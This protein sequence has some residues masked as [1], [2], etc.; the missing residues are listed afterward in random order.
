[1][2]SL[3]LVERA[4][5]LCNRLVLIAL[6]KC[7]ASVCVEIFQLFEQY[8][9]TI[10]L[11]LDI[12]RRL[13][14]FFA[15]LASKFSNFMPILMQAIQLA[16]HYK[17]YP[18]QTSFSSKV[19]GTIFVWHC[20]TPLEMFLIIYLHLRS[21]VDFITKK[22]SSPNVKIQFCKLPQWPMPTNVY[23]KLPTEIMGRNRLVSILKM[24]FSKPL[25]WSE[26]SGTFSLW[27][28]PLKNCVE[29]IGLNIKNMTELVP[30]YLFDETPRQFEI[31]GPLLLDSLKST[32]GS[33]IGS[34]N[35][36]LPDDLRV[37]P[38]DIDNRV[39]ESLF[40][41]PDESLLPTCKGNKQHPILLLKHKDQDN[42]LIGKKLQL[43]SQNQN[44][45]DLKRKV[46]KDA[47][48]KVCSNFPVKRKQID[49]FSRPRK[50]DA[51]VSA[52][53]FDTGHDKLFI[54]NNKPGAERKPLVNNKSSFYAIKPCI[55][56]M[57]KPFS[58]PK[59]AVALQPLFSGMRE[60]TNV[61]DLSRPADNNAKPF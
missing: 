46:V 31:N 39:S 32:G 58:S 36:V 15:E 61:K 9:S 23:G 50:I 11:K 10:T 27:R 19:G 21:M 22:R 30:L 8:K 28:K 33:I 16:L 60:S 59:R 47:E 44:K 18:E 40:E 20:L 26:C 43:P 41:M 34:N 35:T 14:S 38:I 1:M 54:S 2:V 55:M 57:C 24:C 49:F 37:I 25:F 56:S 52:D 3:F 42:E 48:H 17:L 4:T 12:L 5:A 29:A 7:A 6:D 13:V 53:N 51:Y 45:D